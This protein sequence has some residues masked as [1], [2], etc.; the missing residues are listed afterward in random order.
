MDKKE[1][2]EIFGLKCPESSN[3]RNTG[4]LTVA[5]RNG[6]P[7]PEQCEFCYCELK[8]KMNLS[9]AL[10]QLILSI[11]DKLATKIEEET[12]TEN[13]EEDNLVEHIVNEIRKFA[14]A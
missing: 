7:E 10:D 9:I 8:S 12:Y 3:C 6:E 11:L 14:I 1:L 13:R 4:T 5:D 2:I